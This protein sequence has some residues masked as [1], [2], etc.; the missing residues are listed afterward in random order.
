MGAETALPMPKAT[1]GRDEFLYRHFAHLIRKPAVGIILIMLAGLFAYANSFTVPFLLDDYPNIVENPLIRNFS[2]FFNPSPE[3]DRALPHAV[4]LGKDTRVIG[5]L[6]FAVNYRLNGL[7]VTGY[8]I[9]NVSIHILNA[10]LVYLIVL[11]T[12]RTPKMSGQELSPHSSYIALFAALMFVS[13]PIQTQ[14]VTYVVQRFA[15]L[16]TFLCLLSGFFYIRSRLASSEGQSGKLFYACALVS[17]LM[18]M[19]TKEIAFPVPMLIVAYEFMFFREPVRRKL[20]YLLPMLLPMGVIPWLLLGG[21]ASGDIMQQL[22]GAT[23][24]DPVLSRAEYL[25]TQLRVVLTYKR[26][27]FLPVNQ[28]ID[29]DYPIP[30]SFLEPAVFLS[31]L[32]VCGTLILGLFLLHKS[33]GSEPGLR[34]TAYGI[35]WFYATLSVE[36]SFIPITDVIFEHRVYLPSTGAFIALASGI[37]LLIKKWTARRQ[38]IAFI[39]LFLIPVFLVIATHERN[40]VFNSGVSLWEDTARKSPGNARVRHNL[41]IAYHEAGYPSGR[42]LEEML[43][44]V[45]LDPSY[46]PAYV[47]IGNMYLLRGA[48][49]E[50]IRNYEAALAIEPN[51]RKA[52]HNLGLAYEKKGLE[53]KAESYFRK[54]A[55]GKD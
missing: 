30:G 36:S 9:V 5:Y 38:D 27:L 23:T 17:M 12:F 49:D 34:V 3:D 32:L 21:N 4:N 7:A 46:Y 50:A 15:S 11:L 13:H 20:S 33:R 2:F 22:Q 6:T 47:D 52:Y 24:L 14:A 45:E 18:A 53:E 39:A 48:L 42:S 25:L 54:A 44:A 35:F 43:K 28:N 41:G 51:I 10:L 19:L 8:H 31:F 29:Y 37:V 16:A 1:F 40:G 26:L 55:G